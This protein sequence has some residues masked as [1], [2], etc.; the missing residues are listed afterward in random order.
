MQMRHP[1]G[2]TN[3]ASMRTTTAVAS[4]FAAKTML[5]D[6]NIVMAGSSPFFPAEP[7]PSPASLPSDPRSKPSI[8]PVG[9]ADQPAFP[10]LTAQVANLVQ[11]AFAFVGDGLALVDDAE[12]RRRLDVCRTCDR[13]AG[14][15]CTACGCWIGLKARGRAFRC[16]LDRWPEHT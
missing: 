2:K 13:R 8:E 12:Y 5:T 14:K 16:P 7:T 6:V 9:P 15:R 1:K 11:S 10:P 4:Q 3:M